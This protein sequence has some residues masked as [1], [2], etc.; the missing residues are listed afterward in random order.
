MHAFRVPE[1]HCLAMVDR[2]GFIVPASQRLGVLVHLGSRSVRIPCWVESPSGWKLVMSVLKSVRSRMFLATL[3][4]LMIIAGTLFGATVA[5]ADSVQTQS[6]QRASQTEACVA[7]VGETPWQANWGTDATWKPSW[8]QWANKGTGGWTCTRS[9]VWA[10][11]APAHPSAGCIDLSVY[12]ASINFQSGWFLAGSAPAYSN[13][14][15]SVRA[16][17]LGNNVVYAPVGYDAT[18]LCLEA[19]GVL[20]NANVRKLVGSDVYACDVVI[21]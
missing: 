2:V 9:I 17:S 10:R 20:P 5:S 18:T 3:S 6:Y 19:F 11:S 12:S 4:V 16:G 15:C 7:Q 21:T 8:E 1:S 13:S 14:T